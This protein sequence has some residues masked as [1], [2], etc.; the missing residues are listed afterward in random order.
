M[1]EALHL[2]EHKLNEIG[3]LLMN[4]F[5]VIRKESN[6]VI[7]QVCLTQAIKPERNHR[8]TDL[9]EFLIDRIDEPENALENALKVYDVGFKF[10]VESIKS[11]KIRSLS[12]HSNLYYWILKIFGPNSRNTQKCFDDIIESRVW[13]NLKSQ[14]NAESNTPENLTNCAYNSICLIYLEFCNENVPFKVEHLPYLQL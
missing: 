4:S 2:F 8:N 5:Q 11:A 13:I 12:V 10:D 3:D 7:A 14:E 6:S 1:E 9:L